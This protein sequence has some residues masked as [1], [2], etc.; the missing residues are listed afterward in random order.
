MFVSRSRSRNRQR[1][2]RRF[3]F[4]ADR[5]MVRTHYIRMNFGIDNIGDKAF[6]YESVV[7]TP[8]HIALAGSETV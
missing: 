7:D 1:C 8:T 3:E 6:V 4:N 5:A 2:K